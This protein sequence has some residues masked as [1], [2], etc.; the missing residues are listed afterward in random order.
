MAKRSPD[1]SDDLP[2]S[3]AFPGSDDGAGRGGPA[4]PR[5]NK[6]EEIRVEAQRLVDRGEKPTPKAIIQALAARGIVIVSP[7]ASQVLKRMGI[8][9]RPRRKKG[10]AAERTERG[11]ASRE[12]AEPAARALEPRVGAGSGVPAGSGGRSAGDDAFTL[13]DLIAA[14]QFASMAGGPRRAM[15]LLEALEKLV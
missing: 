14:K 12:L 10:Q 2:E 11:A 7:Q 6:S 9:G 5:V 15:R 13:H 8:V 4:E 1:R 3:P